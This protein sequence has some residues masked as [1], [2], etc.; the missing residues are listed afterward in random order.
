MPAV[1]PV[2][3]LCGCQPTC[4]LGPVDD[5]VECADVVW[6]AILVIQVIGVL[7]HV[8]TQDGGPPLGNRAI[9]VGSAFDDQ[10]ALVDRQPGP[11]TAEAGRRG[12]RELFLERGEAAERAL[13]RLADCTGWLATAART[14]D[15]PEQRMVGMTAAVVA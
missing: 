14:H 7:P 8:E 5:V 13:D 10:F 1:T 9:L 3:S 4:N 2:E 15:C 6:A 11:A 12:F